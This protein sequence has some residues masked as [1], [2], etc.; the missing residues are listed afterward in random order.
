[1]LPGLVNPRLCHD[2]HFVHRL[3]Y[4]TSG[5]ICIAL[6]KQAARAASIA[7]ETRTAK[8]FYLA[9]V[10]GCINEPYIII[11]KAIGHDVREKE[12]NHKMCTSDNVYCEKPRRSIT[13]LVALEHGFRK[14]TPATKVLLCPGTG[15][16]HQ[17]RVH[18]RC[19][20]H[21]IIGDYTYSEGQD[22]QPHRTFLHSFRL[23]LNNAIENLDVKCADPFSASDPKNQWIPTNV[24]RSLDENIFSEIYKLMK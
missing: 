4:V 18:C 11:D 17:L 7:F 10:H 8:K 13:V 22:V 21:T 24:I 2:F 9:L 15:R 5:V 1:M 6:N 20:G 12:G 16:R 14:D 23:I 19:I 3:D